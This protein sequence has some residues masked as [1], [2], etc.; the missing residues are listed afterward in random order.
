MATAV[1]LRSESGDDFLF[2]LESYTD[3]RS[4]TEKFVELFSACGED[5]EY[6]WY[7]NVLT[8]DLDETEFKESIQKAL[9]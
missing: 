4:A 8:H 1:S 9:S 6:I 5:W 7:V 3:V 2:L